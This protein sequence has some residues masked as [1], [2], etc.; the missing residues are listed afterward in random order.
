MTSGRASCP[1]WWGSAGAAA[2]SASTRTRVGRSRRRVR[3]GRITAPV[4]P[5]PVMKSQDA[6][7]RGSGMG[8]PA[9]RQP[10]TEG[11]PLSIS[12]RLPVVLGAIG[13]LGFLVLL[14]AGGDTKAAK[15]I[16]KPENVIF[17]LGDGMGDQEVT[18]ARYY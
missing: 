17:F 11:Q 1:P 13:L 5:G 12:K 2:G 7:E 14:S 16:G 18:A 8:Q 4:A 15:Y 10:P 9:P 6:H 3:M